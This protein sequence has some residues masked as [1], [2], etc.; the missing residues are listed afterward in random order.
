MLRSGIPGLVG[1]KV[2]TALCL[3]ASGLALWALADPSAGAR[4][5]IAAH[6]AALFY[7][8]LSK[9]VRRSSLY[10]TL[11]QRT[12]G[13]RLNEE[14]M[15]NMGVSEPEIGVEDDRPLVL[16]AED[17]EVNQLLAVRML[18]RRGYRVALVANAREAVY[19]VSEAGYAMV[20]MDCQMPELDGYAATREIRAT[21]KTEACTRRSW[22]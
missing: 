20:F 10:E 14:V 6:S 11:V 16:V 13:R 18:E 22:P 12:R 3:V 7:F 8:Q 2:N 17:N 4:T 1:M 15:T 9:P 19:A 5:R 21:R